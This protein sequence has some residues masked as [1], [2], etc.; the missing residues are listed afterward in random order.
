[1]LDW[2]LHNPSL[3]IAGGRLVNRCSLVSREHEL[4]H[5]VTRRYSCVGPHDLNS[6][7]V[8]VNL[9]HLNH[10]EPI[11]QMTQVLTSGG[12]EYFVRSSVDREKISGRDIAGIL[13]SE[14]QDIPASQYHVISGGLIVTGNHIHE[15]ILWSRSLDGAGRIG[16]GR[17]SESDRIEV[18]CCPGQRK[19]RRGQGPDHERD[20]TF[21]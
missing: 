12:M 6:G 20:D 4:H 7:Q 1:M 15:P 11:D 9:A 16:Q 5:R 19:E 8:L 10:S 3:H 18:I 17:F 2:K 13:Q 21:H 14:V